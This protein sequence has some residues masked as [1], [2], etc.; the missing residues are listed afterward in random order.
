MQ[1][2][3]KKTSP[4]KF[5]NETTRFLGDGVSFKAKLIGILEVSEARGDRMCQDALCDLKMAI[6]AAGEHKQRITINIAIDGLRL[7]DEKSGDCLYHHPVHKISFIAQDMTD[8][9]AFG[10]IFGSPDTGHRFFGIKTD[11]AASQVVMAMRDLFQVVFTLKKKEIELAKQHLEKTYLPTSPTL[12][13][14]SSTISKVRRKRT[15]PNEKSKIESK[16][17]ASESKNTMV[18]TTAV[19]DLVDLELELNSLQQGLNQ[20]ERITPSDPFGSKDDP[21]GDSFISYPINKLILP[22]PPPSNRDRS[23]R[24]SESSITKTP[25]PNTGPSVDSASESLF[26]SKTAKEFTFSSRELN[27]SHE[28]SSD[29]FNTSFP[30]NTIFEDTAP[31]P[32]HTDP[33]KDEKHEVVKQEIMSQFDVFTEL[34]PLGTGRSKPYIDK[35]HFFQELK[36]PPKKAL[37]ELAT[38][39]PTSAGMQ[40][41]NTYSNSNTIF[42]TDPFGEDPF[43]KEDPFADFSKHDPFESDFQS[44]KTSGA[45]PK[46]VQ[47]APPEPPPRP[48]VTLAE[49]QPPPLP[50]KKQTE[51]ILKPPPRPP[52]SIDEN[53]SEENLIINKS[54][55]EN[56]SPL[57]A[58]QRKSRFETD[59]TT[60]PPERP[61]K[62][63]VTQSS[64]EDYLTPISFQEEHPEKSL[65]SDS[66]DIT[67][68]QLTL[69][70]LNELAAKLKIP[71][72]K[73]SNMTLVQLTNYLST[74]IKTQSAQNEPNFPAFKADF[75]ANFE[76]NDKGT[77]TAPTY[78]RYAVFRELQEE[79]KQT[80]I[81]QVP[82]DIQVVEDKYAALREIDIEHVV[83]EPPHLNYQE[84]EEDSVKELP[85]EEEE[86]RQ[87]PRKTP[88]KS[89]ARSPCTKSP[90]PSAI[91]ELI[92]SNARLNSG[93]LSDVLSGSSPEI[94]NTNSNSDILKK[95]CQDPTGESWAIFD[96][97]PEPRQSEEGMSP[98]SSDSKEFS[99]DWKKQMSKTKS[100]RDP[101]EEGE[102]GEW[103]ADG[104]AIAPRRSIDSYDEDYYE[105]Y[106]RPR[107]RRQWATHGNQGGGHSSSSRDVSPWEEEPRRRGWAGGRQHGPRGHS[108]DRHRVVDS[109]DEDDDYEF[110]DERGRGR[111]F[112][113]HGSKDPE[114]HGGRDLEEDRW[115]EYQS[116]RRYPSNRRRR[117]GGKWCC[118]DWEQGRRR[119]RYDERYR[120]SRESQDSPW[121]DEYPVVA[122]EVE[123]HAHYANKKNSWKQRPSS[124]SEMDRITGEI[125]S[126]R[127]YM[128]TGGSDGERDRNRYK[129]TRR[130]R[131][132]DSQFSDYRHRPKLNSDGDYVEISTP[133]TKK[134]TTSLVPDKK[135]H[136]PSR[137]K[138]STK[139]PELMMAMRKCKTTNK[140]I[141]DS[142]DFVPSDESPI[143]REGKFNFADNPQSPS[144]RQR[145]FKQTRPADRCQSLEESSKLSPRYHQTVKASHSPFEDDFS[146]GD[147]KGEPSSGEVVGNNN[148]ISSI[149]EEPSD[150]PD[151]EEDEDSFKSL[152]SSGNRKKLGLK[153][154]TGRFASAKRQDALKKSGGGELDEIPLPSRNSEL[155]W[156]EDFD[157]SDGARK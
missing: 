83:A 40:N 88:E 69:S 151:A 148:G 38:A 49:V 19:A 136:V 142:N 3:R 132:R 22:P 130:S 149:K 61:K 72:H 95:P 98:W 59:F 56:G 125:K 82:E 77:G 87:E 4:L 155:R 106:E 137:S 15:W 39:A 18:G 29:W 93:S 99:S 45:S 140:A 64:E 44:T 111:Y 75:A 37:N 133:V 81:E 157:D 26:S 41:T 97:P 66:L 25:P 47:C 79:I 147:S 144:S 110:A 89:P 52:H 24:L 28:D 55:G 107:R 48:A 20:M 109:W 60:P 143:I 33:V 127:H 21:F 104:S 80:K 42:A 58:P 141:F 68:S 126:G 46:T 101:Q 92:Q 74:F 1:T 96:P 119:D 90:I 30:S 135:N 8:S 103:W 100:R 10:Y 23:S 16:T 138:R 113:R 114:R 70:G 11:K 7:R 122:N 154:N 84:D 6:R 86:D 120:S 71:P 78:D 116:D 2:L 152:P 102:E 123:D 128:G 14:D 91:T 12:F 153:N 43:V 67:L 85:K 57:P 131:S 17:N 54:S 27:S 35:K 124:A 53:Y 5:K 36:N 51:I 34:D 129:G 156:S 76:G 112:Q 108:F 73:L 117:D 13:S 139:D 31:L 50:P 118:P 9:R 134:Q 32:H 62:S 150:F 94:D 121:E 145:A 63:T 146:P 115:E 65:S 105:C